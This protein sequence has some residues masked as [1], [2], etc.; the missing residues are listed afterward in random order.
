MSTKRRNTSSPEPDD[1]PVSKRQKLPLAEEDSD[2]GFDHP[3]GSE[4]PRIDPTYGQKAA[5]PGL[6]DDAD[7]LSYSPPSDGLEYLRMV[8]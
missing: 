4:L 7:E 3:C 1:S 6:G 5:F 8:R 2:D